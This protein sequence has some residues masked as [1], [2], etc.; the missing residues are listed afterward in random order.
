VRA[1]RSCAGSGRREHSREG[2]AA[3]SRYDEGIAS[4]VACNSSR[5]SNA[6]RLYHIQ[7]TSNNGRPRV[8]TESN[9]ATSRCWSRRKC[10]IVMHMGLGVTQQ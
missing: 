4:M 10:A 2:R 5:K 3:M 6:L 1:A 7:W 8:S 9:I